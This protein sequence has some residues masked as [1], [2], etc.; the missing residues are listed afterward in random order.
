M[1]WSN[2]NNP[3]RHDREGSV[4]F[5]VNRDDY[6]VTPAGWGPTAP[7]CYQGTSMMAVYT[8]PREVPLNIAELERVYK[9]ARTKKM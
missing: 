5:Q 1:C 8:K 3:V 4:V 2:H 6:V 7:V 9:E